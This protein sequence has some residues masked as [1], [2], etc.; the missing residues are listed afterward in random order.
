MTQTLIE[1]SGGAR[2]SRRVV[3]HNHYRRDARVA[4]GISPAG[5]LRP[6]PAL[7]VPCFVISAALLHLTGV[8]LK[9]RRMPYDQHQRFSLICFMSSTRVAATP[10]GSTNM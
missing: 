5:T 6:S 1:A 9:H 3:T 4:A 10:T 8:L 7:L 2:I